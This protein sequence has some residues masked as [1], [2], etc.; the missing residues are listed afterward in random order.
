MSDI[1]HTFM[2]WKSYQIRHLCEH[3]GED[4]AP[5]DYVYH[6]H[7]ESEVTKEED[8]EAHT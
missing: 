2:G 1:E 5:E 4:Y 8:D 6:E 3:C 7:C